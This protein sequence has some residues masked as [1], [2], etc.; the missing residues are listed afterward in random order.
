MEVILIENIEKLGKIGDV[1]NVKDGYARNFL[2]PKKKVLRANKENL[3]IYEEKKTV[4]QQ[5]EKEREK[6]SLEIAK[7]IK[8]SEFI[9]IR[10]ASENGQLYGSVTS[11]DIIKE[12]S[13]NKDI[14][15]YNEQINLKRPLKSLGVFEIEISVYIGIKEKV[16]INVSKTIET[17]K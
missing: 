16:L 5:E 3:K 4:I 11:K 8:G 14:N 15:L 2:L 7:K 10:N 9:I 12:I 17:A 1:V 6:I 13:E